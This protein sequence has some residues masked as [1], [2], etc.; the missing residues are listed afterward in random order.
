MSEIPMEPP[1]INN[2]ENSNLNTNLAI[3]FI[4]YNESTKKFII[5]K[6]A[7]KI[8]SNPENKKIGIISL[9]GKYRTG[10]SFL[11]NKVIINNNESITSGFAVGPTIK[12]C[13][14]GI[15]LWSKPLIINNDSNENKFPVYLIDTEGLG[16][17]DEEINHDSK[18]FLI[19]ILI[20]SLFIYNSIGTIDENAL[21]NL[22]FILNL[23][24]SLK[25]K[26]EQ[27][28]NNININ[29]DK[30]LAKYFPILFWVLRDFSLKLEDAEG[31]PINSNQYL[32]NSLTEQEGT[33]EI[34]L[35]KNII[36]KKIK[37]YFI[38]RYCF[39]LV[40][41]VEDEKELQN[42]MYLPDNKI[43]S[44][45]LTQS[46]NLKQ[47]IYSKVK[48]KNFGG[49]ILSGEMLIDLLESI[50]NSINNGAIPVIENS[51]K[52][53]T[54]NECI[55]NI[56]IFVEKYSQNI[57]NFQK[58][59]M[60]T[61]NFFEELN[62]YN[63]N[64]TKK[65][66]DEYN[67]ICRKMQFDENDIKK[68]D[69]ILKNNLKQEYKKLTQE[70]I[71][72]LKDK[73]NFEINKELDTIFKNKEKILNINYITFINELIQI[74]YKLD[75]SIPDFF[76]KQQ[77][78]FE[79]ILDAIKKYIEEFFVKNKNSVEQ[80]INT[81]LSQKNFLEEKNKKIMDEYAKDKNDFKNTVNKYNDMLIEN[82]LKLKT[83][84]EKIKNFEEEKRILKETYIINSEEKNKEL[85]E[86]I[87]KLNLEINK[88]KIE[89]KTKEEEILL[90]NL[91]KE[92]DNALNIQK[93]NFL[94]N[95]INE[96]KKRYN[97]ENKELSE[98]KTEK[99]HLIANIDKLKIEIKN[100][101]NKINSY[102][103]NNGNDPEK[104]MN[105]TISGKGFYTSNNIGG[106]A[107]SKVLVELMTG[108]NYIKDFLDEIKN[109]TEKILDMNKNILDNIQKDANKKKLKNEN[110]E[111]K[112][113][114]NNI[115]NNINNNKNNYNTDKKIKKNEINDNNIHNQFF[116][117]DKNKNS[118]IISNKTNINRKLNYSNSKENNLSFK[119]KI[120]NHALKKNNSG[121][122]YIDYICEIKTKEKTNKIHRKLINFY[123]LHKSLTEF[124]K[125]KINIP[126][127]DNIFKE[128]NIKNS[129]LENK[130]ELLNNYIEEICKINEIKKS[131]IFQNFFEINI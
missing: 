11:L 97:L 116:S 28:I 122:P 81:L 22:S 23:S 9:V 90:N 62:K 101:K 128:E 10:K 36:R 79:K 34:I 130:Q 3:P 31:N 112:N 119:I 18:I 37:N 118:E 125:D 58:E 46:L 129:S 87:N 99:I 49:K 71:N 92:Q 120:I 30:E 74:K 83:M 103:I 60:E 8:I 51:W 91:N 88:L 124:F 6:E 69:E 35:E 105:M 75:S 1:I 54:D 64:T 82:K 15:W 117:N 7:K 25:L 19:S 106:R 56:K 93:I 43:R 16:A 12:P 110:E 72:L 121:K 107:S 32:E 40:R 47:S 2:I 5:N 42:L 123:S 102:E 20:S 113:L 4:T 89:L 104:N 100:L 29:E 26:N 94:E 111:L 39:P 14:K 114:N 96:W 108:Q 50:I 109:N 55:K 59:K 86:Q 98:I 78:S 67:N 63:E 27:N 73:Y 70:N 85:N 84:E 44:E 77:I 131:L 95:E 41:P 115:I 48:P 38:E 126:D 17:Y 24:K 13:T 68:Y 127:K 52:Y 80:K 45:F 66:I 53:I 57:I 21:S 76:L 65:L 33:S 61:E